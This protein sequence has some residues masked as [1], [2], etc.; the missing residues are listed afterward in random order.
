[1]ID[2]DIINAWGEA[3]ARAAF[4]RCCGSRSWAA[5][6]AGRRPFPTEADLFVSAEEDWRGLTR[7]DWLEAF[8]AHPR[9]G[10]L[11]SLRQKFAATAAWPEGEQAGVRGAP[12]EVLRALAEGNGAYE[13]RFGYLF[14]V[15]ATGKTAE[16]MLA[17]L[18]RRLANGPD[19]ELLLAAAEQEQITRLR[20]QKLTP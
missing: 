13:A 17:L 1:M 19:E 14:I 7:E 18:R 5:R 11:D 16:E 8:A 2:L 3:E 20:L 12:E 15:C 9:I 4:L 10:D 6:M